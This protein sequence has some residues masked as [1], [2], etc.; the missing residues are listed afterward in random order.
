MRPWGVSFED[1]IS[2]FV[3]PPAFVLD[4]GMPD[5]GDASERLVVLTGPVAELSLV[6]GGKSAEELHVLVGEVLMC[7]S[8]VPGLGFSG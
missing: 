4:N 8:G 1:E 3:D 5:A 7:P 2:L 6:G